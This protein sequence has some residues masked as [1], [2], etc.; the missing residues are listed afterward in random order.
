[1]SWILAPC[2]QFRAYIIDLSDTFGG[3]FI[4]M[5]M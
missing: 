5:L 3:H 4:L 1:M 2:R